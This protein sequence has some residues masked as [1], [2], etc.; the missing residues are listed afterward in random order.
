MS[1]PIPVKYSTPRYLSDGGVAEIKEATSNKVASFIFGRKR[2]NLQFCWSRLTPLLGTPQLD[3]GLQICDSGYYDI[4]VPHHW[5]HQNPQF[6]VVVRLDEHK[7][8]VRRMADPPFYKLYSNFFTSP[9]PVSDGSC[10]RPVRVI[11]VTVNA[12]VVRR[13]VC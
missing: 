3:Y 9:W 4:P 7:M 6:I 10:W 12:T 5:L 8:Q 13:M 1:I 2:R 11:R